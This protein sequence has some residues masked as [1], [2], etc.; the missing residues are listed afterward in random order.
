MMNC[1]FLE[2]S[3]NDVLNKIINNFGLPIEK[4]QLF[5]NDEIIDF[6]QI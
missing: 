5:I 6:S 1:E 3:G 2:K 4:P